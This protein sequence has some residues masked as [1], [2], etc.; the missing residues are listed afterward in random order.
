LNRRTKPDLRELYQRR[1]GDKR[2]QVGA[3]PTHPIAREERLSVARNAQGNVIRFS[4]VLHPDAR[5]LPS[6]RSKTKKLP[7]R[8]A[9]APRLARHA[10]PP[11]HV[12][13]KLQVGASNASP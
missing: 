11:K 6:G 4:G 8:P 12:A 9:H 3:E 1:L 10:A 5:L 2:R 7:S 13:R